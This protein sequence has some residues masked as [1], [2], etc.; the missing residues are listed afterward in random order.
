MAKRGGTDM[1]VSKTWLS[2][3]SIAA[4]FPPDSYQSQSVW[5]FQTI[6]SS[7]FENPRFVAVEVICCFVLQ[8]FLDAVASPAPL[9]AFMWWK[10]MKTVEKNTYSIEYSHQNPNH[11]V[12]YGVVLY[13]SQKSENSKFSKLENQVTC[14]ALQIL[15]LNLKLCF[16]CGTTFECFCI[17]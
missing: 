1:I 16:F 4:L 3:S 7:A 2:D 17:W 5:L 11:L 8:R 9:M 6:S 12:N 10:L 14:A 15:N 13:P